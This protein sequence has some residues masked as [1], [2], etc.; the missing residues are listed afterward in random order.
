VAPIAGPDREL[1]PPRARVARPAFD[2][3]R[4]LRQ[5]VG[6]ATPAPQHGRTS[7]ASRRP[8]AGAR[9][10]RGPWPRPDPEASLLLG[11]AEET[12]EINAHQLGGRYVEANDRPRALQPRQPRR[13]WKAERAAGRCAKVLSNSAA[14]HDSAAEPQA[15]A[16]D[17]GHAGSPSRRVEGGPLHLLVVPGQPR[18]ARVRPTNSPTP[19]S[20]R[21]PGST[22]T[23]R[24]THSGPH[25]LRLRPLRPLVDRSGPDAPWLSARSTASTPQWCCPG[26]GGHT[27]LAETRNPAPHGPG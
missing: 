1:A 17:I 16:F 19:R 23:G 8:Q 27:P 11:R 14:T 5:R 2:R 15:A 13:Y 12:L 6:R 26:H 25:R 18:P 24:L 22:R 20:R 7:S 10:A 21:D 3:C 9:R 4:S